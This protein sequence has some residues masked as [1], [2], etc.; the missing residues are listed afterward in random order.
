MTDIH[1]EVLKRMIDNR[2]SLIRS[3]SWLV[4]FIV[5]L[6]LVSVGVIVTHKSIWQ[7]IVPSVCLCVNATTLIGTV[8]RIKRSR[9]ALQKLT[10][11]YATR[12][13]VLEVT[14]DVGV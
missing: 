12:L 13:F 4:A 11:E 1:L 2:R 3:D 9:A 10:N 6:M 7:M 14:S 5:F 8:A